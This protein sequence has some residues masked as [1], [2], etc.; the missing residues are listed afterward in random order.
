MPCPAHDDS[1]PSLD[2]KEGNEGRVIAICRAGCELDQVL[3]A[4]GLDWNDL[5]S[6]DRRDHDPNL[7]SPAGPIEATYDYVNEDGKLLFQV[8]RAEGKKFLQRRPDASRRSGWEW[9]LGDTRRPLYRL[10]E[11]IQA[12]SGGLTIFLTEGEK[13][14]DAVR[15]TGAVGTCNPHGAG[16]WL[17]EHTETLRE[18]DVIIIADQ[19]EPGRKHARVVAKALTGVARRVR[20]AQSAVGKDVSDHLKAGHKLEDLVLLTQEEVEPFTAQDITEFVGGDRGFDWIVEGLIERGER[21]MVTGFEGKGKTTLLRQMAVC[22]ASGR[23]PFT[24]KK[25][26]KLRVLYVDCEN[27]ARL[28]RRRFH[29][30]VKLA[31]EEDGPFPIGH[32]YIVSR[33]EGIDL[34]S[35][36]GEWLIEQVTAFKPDVLFIGPLYQLHFEDPNNEQAARRVGKVLRDVTV[37]GNCAL[38]LEAHSGKSEGVGGYRGLRPIGSSFWLRWP[39]FGYGL[40]PIAND[41]MRVE[42]KEW[43]GPR[44]ERDWPTLLERSSPWPWAGV[45]QAARVPQRR[46]PTRPIPRSYIEPQERDE[47]EPF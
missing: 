2:V 26:P 8:V 11:V 32:F 16:K 35:D 45:Y 33:P 4:A 39:E 30:L 19:D 1:K 7:W 21:L 22:L 28:S 38:I 47:D 5:F 6:E 15:R 27:G 9:K 34:T 12:V 37:R 41:A 23:H 36:D 29:V 44:D 10:P 24:R 40:A 43:R 25:I 18:A 20:V 13:D 14:A 3:I 42:F 31:E 17:P 46:D